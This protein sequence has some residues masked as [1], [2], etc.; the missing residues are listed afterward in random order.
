VTRRAVIGSSSYVLADELRWARS[1]RDRRKGL[2]GSTPLR[3]G[4][5]LVID[6][7]FQVHTVGMDFPIDVVFCDKQWVVRHVVRNMRPG[8]LSK[9]VWGARYALELPAGVAPPELRP[10]DSLIV[11]PEGSDR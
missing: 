7:A 10:G 11:D 6:K 2:L 3:P 1:G 4:Q 8:R 9:L 5:G